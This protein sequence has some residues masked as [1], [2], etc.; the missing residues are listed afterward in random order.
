MLQQKVRDCILEIPEF[1]KPGVSFKD[2]TPLLNNASLSNEILDHM[3]EWA[4]PLR[5]D[6]IAGLESRGF[7]FG[8]ALAQRLGVG[9]IPIRKPGKLPRSVFSHSYELEYG[10]ATLEL[11]QEDIKPG[12]RVLIHDDLLA[13]GGTVSAAIALIERAGSEVAGLHFIIELTFLS[14]KTKLPPSVPYYSVVQY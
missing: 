8:F 5:P 1:P 10:E 14:G 9:F 7:M 12:S 13:T 4:E 3:T 2:I 11:H 6:Y